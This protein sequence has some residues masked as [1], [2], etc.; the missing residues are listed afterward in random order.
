MPA[1][2]AERLHS[3]LLDRDTVG[4][5]ADVRKN[6]PAARSERALHRVC[7]G[8][9]DPDDPDVG[10][11]ALHVG[12]DP[13]DQA[14]APDGDE[15]RVDRLAEL[16]QDLHRDGALTGDHVGVVVG[17]D[18]CELATPD[19]AHRL[20]VR[21]VVGVALEHDRRP[22]RRD[23]VDLDLG[24]RHRHH[25]RGVGTEPPCRE[26]DALGVVPGRGGDDTAP[27]RC[28]GQA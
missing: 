21:V 7:V 20:G 10:P 27:Q 15:D 9:L 12:G 22:E 8:R 17:M 14:A 1:C 13:P 23:R 26:R 16:P 28:C 2:E 25:D 19:D 5:E 24:R 11:E 6:D 18:E 3:H 4:E